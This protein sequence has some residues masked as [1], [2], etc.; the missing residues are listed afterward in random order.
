MW[1]VVVVQRNIV[2]FAVIIIIIIKPNNLY[3]LA[4]LAEFFSLLRLC[5]VVVIFREI[6]GVSVPG[7]SGER[8]ANTATRSSQAAAEPV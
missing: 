1:R 3:A 4:G 7:G 8:S 5:I 6:H 2:L